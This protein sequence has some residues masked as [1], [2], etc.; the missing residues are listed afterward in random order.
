MWQEG[1]FLSLFSSLLPFSSFLFYSFRFSLPF[2]ALYYIN[3]HP[4]WGS[5][6]RMIFK[7]A[8]WAPLAL[9]APRASPPSPP[10]SPHEPSH[11]RLCCR[12]TQVSPRGDRWHAGGRELGEGPGRQPRSPGRTR[13]QGEQKHVL[14][15][16][17]GRG[18]WPPLQ[19]VSEKPSWTPLWWNVL[20][21]QGGPRHTTFRT[22]TSD[23]TW[24][25]LRT[26]FA[27]SASGRGRQETRFSCLISGLRSLR[28]HRRDRRKWALWRMN[29]TGCTFSQIYDPNYCLGNRKRRQKLKS[30]FMNPG[31]MSPKMKRRS[32]VTCNTHCTRGLQSFSVSVW[33]LNPTLFVLSLH[34]RAS[35]QLPVYSRLSRYTS[36]LSPDVSFFKVRAMFY[37]LSV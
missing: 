10:S 15:G 29:L 9:P 28:S 6:W 30:Y 1:F 17:G 36:V 31:K 5:T 23:S 34:V 11:Q 20:W 2:F 14:R 26:L 21:V 3:L 4:T 37:A 19:G 13:R 18:S 32:T 16:A 22:N 25:W 8:G 24:D 27:S 33:N 7:E 35:H 12:R